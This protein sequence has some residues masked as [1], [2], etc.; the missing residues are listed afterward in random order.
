[1]SFSP[2]HTTPFSVTDI[3][4]P[5]EESYKKQQLEAGIAPLGH[6]GQRGQG[7]AAGMAAA[8]AGMGGMTGAVTNPYH[9]YVPQ[10]SH[11]TSSFPSQ[12]CNGSDL[13]PYADPMAGRHSSASWYSTSQDPRLA[14]KFEGFIFS[15]S[16]LS[17]PFLLGLVT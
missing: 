15:I 9:N 14:S 5:I 3:L 4:S 11:H 13:N 12:Y 7:S 2:K 17:L 8:A 1:M 10:L 16:L 6:Y